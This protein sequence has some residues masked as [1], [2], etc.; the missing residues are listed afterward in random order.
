MVRLQAELGKQPNGR[1][2]FIVQALIV[3]A[4]TFLT[5]GAEAAHTLS[6]SLYDGRGAWHLCERGCG[7]S[8]RDWAADALTGAAYLRWR[9]NGDRFVL[10]LMRGLE[11][12]APAY[13]IC[14]SSACPW[15]DEPEWDAVAAMRMYAV[16]RDPAALKNAE[17]DYAYVRAG[18]TFA[19]G[20]C[21]EIPF[22]RPFGAGGGLK[23]LETS[24]T[25]IKA[26]L[27]LYGATHSAPYLRDAVAQYASVRKRFLDP[28]APLYTVYLFD[29]RAHCTQL[30]HRFFASVNGEMM[31][32]GLMLYRYTAQRH[33]LREALATERTVE[34]RL[35]DSA[36]VFAD[37]QAENDI[38]EPLV[39]AMY[40]LA[41]AAD[42]AS[43][44]A[45][46]LRNARA[47]VAEDRDARGWYGRF[48]DGPTPDWNVTAWQTNGGLALA[49]AA[50]ALDPDG[51]PDEGA[52]RG[53]RVVW[54][55]ITALPSS[56]GF[57]GTAIAVMGTIGERCCESGHAAVS[58]D[59]VRTFDE[60]GIWQNKSSAGVPIHNAVLFAWRWKTA[61][62]HTLRFD[63][64]PYNAK[65]G[66]TFLHT[67][68]VRTV[69]LELQQSGG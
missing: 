15:S 27:L 29:D 65:E 36:G 68:S 1:M 60:T 5:Y 18:K 30:P 16:T 32:D 22:Q 24:A 64:A 51:V 8:S 43:A 25:A 47:A 23:T 13:T 45:W 66:R 34:K 3:A 26:A 61:G 48:F 12:T 46:I 20:A 31:D 17:G 9:V 19:L 39:E 53:S 59:G 56:I 37:L 57:T 21:P 2:L 69:R 42:R 52:W 62:K 6:S 38:V 67:Q 7:V 11:R 54:R 58:I 4:L 44:R 35:A 10:S 63:A 14:D 41:V 40:D 28:L 55:E 33:Y 49:I 50:A